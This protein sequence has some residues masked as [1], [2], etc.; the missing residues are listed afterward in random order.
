MTEIWQHLGITAIIAA[1]IGWCFRE[2]IK[3]W[4]DKDVADYKSRL[5]S[6]KQIEMEKL[7]AS[8]I[9]QATEH[10]I[11]F[12]SLHEKQAEIIAETYKRLKRFYDN[13]LSYTDLFEGASEPSRSEKLKTVNEAYQE[14]WQYYPLHAIYFPKIT[15]KRVTELVNTLTSIT[16]RMNQGLATYDKKAQIAARVG[17]DMPEDPWDKAYEK[18]QKLVPPLLEA[19]EADFHRILGVKEDIPQDNSEVPTEKPQET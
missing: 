11:R 4:L 12:R 16:R 7:R 9:Q 17:K 1:L 19:M 5:E 2:G 3:H 13:V 10:E 18:M 6:E 8:L 14:F 15:R